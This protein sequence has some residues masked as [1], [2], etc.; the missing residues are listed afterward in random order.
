MT[1]NDLTPAQ[2]PTVTIHLMYFYIVI[3]A[4]IYFLNI[5]YNWYVCMHAKSLQSCPTLQC[6]RW[7]PVRVRP[8]DFPGKNTWIGCHALFQGIF[9]TQESNPYL[10]HLLHCTQVLYPLSHLRSPTVEHYLALKK[11]DSNTCYTWMN[12][13][14][15]MLS[16][17]NQSQEDKHCMIPLIWDNWSNS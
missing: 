17:I 8:W 1:M 6:Y 2:F 12:L 4:S 13:E 5:L 14:D 3:F 7:Q 16:E 15:I 10:Q 9:P 11:E